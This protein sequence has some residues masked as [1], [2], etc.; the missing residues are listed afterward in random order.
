M[1]LQTLYLPVID[2]K[3]ISEYDNLIISKNIKPYYHFDYANVLD[4][5]MLYAT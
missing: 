4:S 3:T 1:I 5:K 2:T